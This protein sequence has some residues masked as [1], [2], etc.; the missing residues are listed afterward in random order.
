MVARLSQPDARE[1][2]Q[3]TNQP[4]TERLKLEA[5]G[6]RERLDILALDFADGTLTSGQLRTA[7][8][9]LRSRLSAIEAEL[10]DAGRV[11]L[12]GPLV[13][14]DDVAASWAALTVPRK[15]AVIDALAIITL[16]PVGRGVRNFDP[17]TVGIDWR[18]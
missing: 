1:L 6:L 3:T 12:L 17:D 18:S 7:T 10:A 5:V 2:T 11:D 4:D 15:R 9:R 14:A 13:G 16:R 8:E